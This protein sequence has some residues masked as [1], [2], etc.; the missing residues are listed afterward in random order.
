MTKIGRFLLPALAAVALSAPARA[1]ETPPPPKD[2]PLAIEGEVGGVSLSLKPRAMIRVRAEVTG[3]RDLSGADPTTVLS[4][5]ARAGFVAKGG[6]WMSLTMDIQDVRIWGSEVAPPGAPPDPTLFDYS[7]GGL[8]MHQAYIGMNAGTL[9]VKLGRQE[10]N[11]E[12]QRIVGAV[13]WTQ[14]ARSFDALHAKL[15]MGDHWLSSFAAQISDSDVAGPDGP[16]PDRWLLGLHG[17]L[18]FLDMMNLAPIAL[19]DSHSGLD[20]IR[21][22]TGARYHGGVV[23]L[24]WDLEGYYQGAYV[25][26]GLTTAFL[27]AGNASYGLDMMLKPRFG[28]LVDFVSG[29]TDPTSSEG[30]SA[31]DTMF[32][33]NHK[34][35]GFADL[36]LNLPLHTA[37]Q[38]LVDAAVYAKVAEGPFKAVAA[39]HGF[40][41]ASP[42]SDVSPL[43]GV[44]P[45]LKVFAAIGKHLNVAGGGAVFIPMGE[46]LGRGDQIM[47]W[48]FLQLE[49]KL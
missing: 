16:L 40:A 2:E 39:F 20:R 5:R 7:A 26:D 12:N 15:G 38:G 36:F 42:A 30:I 24:L 14:Q 9:E 8:D 31:F 25:A 34:F 35:Y 13:A 23:G 49:G 3:A 21:W 27:V 32:A 41:A 47:P 22:T 17:S 6:E 10:I 45:D 46:A 48:L 37:Q 19:V 44:E 11:I 43:Y 18:R 28:A 4:Q 33:T 1:D 29:D